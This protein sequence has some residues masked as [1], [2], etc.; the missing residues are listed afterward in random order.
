MLVPNNPNSTKNITIY[1]F[2][3]RKYKT[4]ELV[5]Q[6]IVHFSIEGDI[7]WKESNEYKIQ[8]EIEE[9]R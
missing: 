5:D 9:V 4:D 7:I 8:E 2:F 6:L 3:V 1:D